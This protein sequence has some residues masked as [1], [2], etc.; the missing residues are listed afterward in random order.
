MKKRLGV[1]RKVVK[2]GGS[3]VIA[4]PRELRVEMRL[5]IGDR[6]RL[7]WD[8]EVGIITKEATRYGRVKD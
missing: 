5:R 4:L 3:H 2:I 6:V 7:E 1:V 8:D